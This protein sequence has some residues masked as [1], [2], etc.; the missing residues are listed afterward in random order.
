MSAS[1]SLTA[2]LTRS[3][4]SGAA[5]GLV[6]CAFDRTSTFA[7]AAAGVASLE[8][9]APMNVDTTMGLASAGK[10]LVS[11]AVLRLVERDGL[12]LDS[13][14]ELVKVVPELGKG[15]EGSHTLRHLLTHTSGL[16]IEFSS[17]EVAWLLEQETMNL[18][19]PRPLNAFEH[20][21]I[22]RLA[23][24]GTAYHYGRSPGFL[25][26]FILRKTG[27]NFRQAMQDLVLSPL[28]VH[29]DTLDTFC[30]PLMKLDCAEICA[31]GPDGIFVPLPSGFEVPMY[32]GHV[33]AGFLPLADGPF[34]GKLPVFAEVLRLFFNNTA[35]AA[36]GKSLLSPELFEQATAD[37]LKKRGIDIKQRPFWQSPLPNR[38]SDLQSWAKPKT[39][40]SNDALGWSLLQTLVHRAETHTGLKPGTLEWGGLMNTYFFLDVSSGLGGV[41]SAQY[42]PF[43]DPKMLEARDEFA[44]WVYEHGRG[45]DGKRAKARL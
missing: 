38:T 44:R 8:T 37:D 23:E 26:L 45:Q 5:P 31:R 27:T 15:Y 17:V 30:T 22:P 12:N 32:E 13:H 41:I 16:G 33:P 40:G 20:Y 35:P 14:N 10:I 7:S 2:L 11:L 18:G 19:H 3:I 1:D 24:A 25:A 34:I 21:N 29:P 28:G 43:L 42:L 6:A 9:G 36:G 4:H 39:Q